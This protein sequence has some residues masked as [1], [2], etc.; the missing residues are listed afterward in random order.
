MISVCLASYNGEKYI[1]EQIS[2]I[3][4]QLSDN[5][6]LIISDDGSTDNTIAIVYAFNDRRIRI[7]D[8]HQVC[9]K[10]KYS[11]SHYNVTSNFENALQ[12]VSGDYVF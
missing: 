9:N 8:N 6:E 10:H 11:Q 2:S 7:Y 12:Y 1:K 5:D 3:L 4:V